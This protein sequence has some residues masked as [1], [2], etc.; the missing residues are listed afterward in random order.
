MVDLERVKG[1]NSGDNPLYNLAKDIGAYLEPLGLPQGTAVSLADCLGNI[2]RSGIV[3]AIILEL[4]Q[5][6][7][8]TGLEVIVLPPTLEFNVYLIE[9]QQLLDHRQAEIIEGIGSSHDR[10]ADFASMLS[11]PAPIT[12][13]IHVLNPD[14]YPRTLD[15]SIGTFSRR[16]TLAQLLFSGN[17]RGLETSEKVV[18]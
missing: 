10:F 12:T 14:R 15:D 3:K 7:A 1:S 6:A 17:A 9:P 4:K 2:Y 13:T 11:S 16:R 18:G 5:T 8:D